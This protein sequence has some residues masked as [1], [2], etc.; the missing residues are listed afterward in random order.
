M[1]SAT[2]ALFPDD[3][4]A[5]EVGA[6]PR[7]WRRVRICDLATSI[8][9]GLTRGASAEA[10]GPAFLRITDIQGGKVDWA[11]VPYCKVNADELEKYQLRAG[12]IVVARTGASTGENMFVRATP[13]AVFAS[14]LVRFQF[15]RL[16]YFTADPD[17]R[18]GA[19]V[20]NRTVTLKDTWA[21]IQGRGEG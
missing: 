19:P 20:F 2:A 6:I 5:S 11:A 13:L 14:Y 12:D 1:D 3:F 17:T 10:V 21:K 4:E 9:Y 7:G 18:P 15:E 16:G 8:Q